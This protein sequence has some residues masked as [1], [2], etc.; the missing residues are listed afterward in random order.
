MGCTAVP[1]E[2][3]SAGFMA[4]LLS[5]QHVTH[6]AEQPLLI[7]ILWAHI[8]IHS[9]GKCGGYRVDLS[10]CQVPLLELLG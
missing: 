5:L 6:A 9:S 3:N 8:H 2:L 1:S 4:F 10:W 7:N